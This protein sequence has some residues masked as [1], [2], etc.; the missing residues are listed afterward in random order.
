MDRDRS[1][2]QAIVLRNRDV[3][4]VDD[5]PAVLQVLEGWLTASGWLPVSARCSQ[6]ALA[7][8]RRSNF[9]IALVDYRLDDGANGIRLGR[10][11]LSKFGLPFLLIS[12]YLN[13]DLVVQAM[14]AGALDVIDKPLSKERVLALLDSAVGRPRRAPALASPDHQSGSGEQNGL[15]I[16]PAAFRWSGMVLGVCDSDD[17]PRTISLWARAI[18]SSPSNIEETCR[19]CGVG[20]NE[21]KNLARFLR[22]ISLNRGHR[23]LLSTYFDVH[24]ERTLS[25]LFDAA[26]LPRDSSSVPLREFFLNQTFIQT[27]KPCLQ[28]WAHLAGNSSLFG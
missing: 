11:L 1:A 6:E 16:H 18:A 19:L 17:D 14:K 13:T 8:G 25:R 3:L 21:S 15:L 24:D 7:L 12:G 5:E 28:E 4:L 10:A 22:A 26:R 27:S 20:T 2:L 23:D 9:A